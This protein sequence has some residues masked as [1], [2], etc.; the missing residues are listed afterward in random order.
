[1]ADEPT[2][3][4]IECAPNGPLLVHGVA[5]LRNSRGEALPV[6]RV[7][8][9]CRCGASAKRPYCDGTHAKTGWSSARAG[10]PPPDRY[11]D[12]RAGD[13]TVQD[14]RAICCHAAHCVND[15]G[16]VFSLERRPWI[17]PAGASAAEL[18]ALAHKCPSGALRVLVDGRAVPEPVEAASVRI[19]KDGPYEV[20]GNVLLR[21]D[22]G[23]QP[24]IPQRYALC[25]CGASMNKPFCDGSHAT[26]PFQDPAN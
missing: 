10:T 2:A 13:V 14:N 8:A 7:T 9:L 24:P 16:A 3:P 5:E 26:A 1:M 19:A 18:I 12:Y 17:D 21:G 22:T 15:L 6:K 11:R 4:S 25:R 23:A 20:R